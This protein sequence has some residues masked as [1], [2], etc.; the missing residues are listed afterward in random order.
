MSDVL[1]RNV[2]D[3]VLQALKRRAEMHH[4]SLQGELLTILE[5]AALPRMS[6]E[7]HVRLAN[8]MRERLAK[9]GRHFGDSVADLRE[10]RER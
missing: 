4:R 7:E 6:P 3:Q 9:T 5:E 8:E 1:V 2:P 10:D